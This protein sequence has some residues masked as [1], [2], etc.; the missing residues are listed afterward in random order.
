MRFFFNKTD[1]YRSLTTNMTKVLHIDLTILLETEQKIRDV[2]RF[3][4]I[5][6]TKYRYTNV[7][8]RGC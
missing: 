1:N 6:H 2:S 4:S 5:K 3:L 7:S 8:E